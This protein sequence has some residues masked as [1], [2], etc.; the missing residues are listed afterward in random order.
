MSDFR[1][2]VI[3]SATGG[4]PG[5]RPEIVSG[6]HY[7]CIAADGTFA[8]RADNNSQIESKLGHYF[9]DDKAPDFG[10]LTF[11]NYTAAAITVI[12]YAG[13]VFYKPT[14][15]T[16]LS[17]VQVTVASVTKNA[18]TYTKGTTASLASGATIA[19]SG[20]DGGGQVRKSFSVFNDHATDELRV[21]GANGT[22]GHKVPA[23]T[24]YP[25]ETGGNLILHNPGAN[26]IT[27][28]VMEVFY[29]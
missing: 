17:S 6:R 18:P 10:K 3:P 4:M 21:R 23:Q 12:Y 20:V 13:Q 7:A 11:Y 28:Y 2:I 19:F 16:T 14:T 24:G 27:Y 5:I 1:T 22:A 26:S 15:N 9:G 25:V 8:V 29:S